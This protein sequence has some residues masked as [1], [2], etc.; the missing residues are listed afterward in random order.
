MA[1]ELGP[2]GIHVAHLVIDSGVDTAWVRARIEA[3]GATG[4]LEPDRLM[5]PATIA[6]TY[7]QLH[8]QPRD[9]WTHEM[10]LRPYGESW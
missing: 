2:Q 1:R 6:E 3:R 5:N 10:D 4:R 7:W 9:G 8:N